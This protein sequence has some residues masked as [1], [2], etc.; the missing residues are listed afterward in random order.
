MD[1]ILVTSDYYLDIFRP[2]VRALKA[3]TTAAFKVSPVER[4]GAGREGEAAE[5]DLAVDEMF[6]LEW[7]AC[8]TTQ[9]VKA[10]VC[11]GASREALICQLCYYHDGKVAICK[12]S[13]GSFLQSPLRFT[14]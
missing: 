4:K 14:A 12:K 10:S 11:F 9:A 3:L 6:L 1:N 13:R 2:S 8:Y 7:Q 5:G